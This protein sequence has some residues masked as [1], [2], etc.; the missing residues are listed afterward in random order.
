MLLV[1]SCR[2]F[3]HR[4]AHQDLLCL[5]A[6]ASTTAAAAKPKELCR[7]A[8]LGASGYTGAEVMRLA[9][10]HPYLTIKALT[11]EKQAGKVGGQLAGRQEAKAGTVAVAFRVA[12]A[13]G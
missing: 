1:R 10:L 11:G 12:A 6:P 13:V 8:V 7:V 2:M 5:Q 3:R 9:A 4:D